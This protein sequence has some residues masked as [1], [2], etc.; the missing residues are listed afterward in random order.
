MTKGIV[1]PYEI[2]EDSGKH[3]QSNDS[4]HCYPLHVTVQLSGSVPPG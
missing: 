1:I 4:T 3:E 2:N